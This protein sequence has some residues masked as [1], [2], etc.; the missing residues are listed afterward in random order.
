VQGAP[1]TIAA[2]QTYALLQLGALAKKLENTTKIGDFAKMAKE[3]E[4]EVRELLAILAR[5]F[6]LQDAI[7]VLELDESPDEVDVH[8]LGLKAARQDRR[9]DIS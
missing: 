3:A 4:S 8:R 2:T 5:C 9:D 1:E 7:D 6:E